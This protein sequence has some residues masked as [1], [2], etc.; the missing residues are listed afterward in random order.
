MEFQT[1]KFESC[2]RRKSLHCTGY[3]KPY[4]RSLLWGG[5]QSVPGIW[6]L[7]ET[8]DRVC[9][10]PDAASRQIRRK[11][12][13]QF[14]YFSWDEEWRFVTKFN[15]IFFTLGTIMI[16]KLFRQNQNDLF[17]PIGDTFYVV[18]AFTGRFEWQLFK[19]FHGDKTFK[20]TFR[21]IV[22]QRVI[23][24]TGSS[25]KRRFLRC[26]KPTSP[27]AIYERVPSSRFWDFIV[28]PNTKSKYGKPVRWV[29]LTDGN[30]F[31]GFLH[32]NI[33]FLRLTTFFFDCET[34]IS[35]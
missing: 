32:K 26:Q 16:V 6:N 28:Y 21:T 11:S 20:I 27:C 9:C 29:V 23:I 8:Q 18:S 1:I 35:K 25:W 14:L 31:K 24:L 17:L 15:G 10:I 19:T 34:F 2:I 7:V 22:H 13:R 30:F 33:Y 4:F 12:A 5:L 3:R